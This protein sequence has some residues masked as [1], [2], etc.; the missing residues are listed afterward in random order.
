[1][2]S[3]SNTRSIRDDRH[4]TSRSS[5][6]KAVSSI[7]DDYNYYISLKIVTMKTQEISK[8]STEPEVGHFERSGVNLN[9]G[10][11]TRS[12]HVGL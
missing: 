11:K 9:C 6:L 1:M 5:E 7:D 2:S 12:E 10:Y 8:N 3:C 4:W